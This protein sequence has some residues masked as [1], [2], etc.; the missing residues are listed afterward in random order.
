MYLAGV[1]QP[2]LIADSSRV[3]RE[4][5]AGA[6]WLPQA[7]PHAPSCR[8]RDPL[9]CMCLSPV[10]H[11]LISTG[12]S[13]CSVAYHNYT[14]QGINI[15]R[16]TVLQGLTTVTRSDPLAQDAML[17]ML[18][19]RLR[20]FFEADEARPPLKV[21]ACVS[22]K[23]RHFC[24]EHAKSRSGAADCVIPLVSPCFPLL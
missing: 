9:P 18:L 19:P 7:L 22:A 14:G 2:V 3:W 5:P 16:F 8:A 1:A 17:E 12:N 6:G 4:P 20:Q 10:L 21:D 11:S 13:C 24:C 23:V 15:A